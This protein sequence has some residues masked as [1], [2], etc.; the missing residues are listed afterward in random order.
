MN[1]EI[2]PLTKEAL[3]ALMKQIDNEINKPKRK[4]AFLAIDIKTNKS[5]YCGSADYPLR[6]I[7]EKLK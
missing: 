7:G 3:E 4:V 1:I 6:K 5:V 2:K